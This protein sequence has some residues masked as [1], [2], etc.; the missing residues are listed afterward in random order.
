MIGDDYEMKSGGHEGEGRRFHYCL[1]M[2][3]ESEERR[4]KEEEED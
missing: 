1:Q 3:E 4:K 2:E